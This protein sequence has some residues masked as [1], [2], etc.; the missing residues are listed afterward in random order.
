MEIKKLY[1]QDQEELDTGEDSLQGSSSI[2]AI[3]LQNSKPV[4]P[5]YFNQVSTINPWRLIESWETSREFKN[6]VKQNPGYRYKTVADVLFSVKE[7]LLVNYPEMNK[8]RSDLIHITHTMSKNFT[9]TVESYL[10]QDLNLSESQ[11]KALRSFIKLDR[12]YKKVKIKEVNFLGSITHEQ[13]ERCA[14]SFQEIGTLI[15]DKYKKNIPAITL[16]IQEENDQEAAFVKDDKENPM[17]VVHMRENRPLMMSEILHEYG[18]LIENYNPRVMSMTNDFLRERILSEDKCTIEEFSL[19]YN[20]VFAEW[21]KNEIIY[22]NDLMDPYMGKTYG[23]LMKSNCSS[24]LL[25]TG[26]QALYLDP[27]KL[28]L[29][30]P[31]C[32]KIVS[33]L[34]HGAI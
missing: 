7:N 11:V 2:S 16:V 14:K 15:P 27:I 22:P 24:E 9:S 21:N 26:L 3:L 19:Q 31:G 25:S 13:A 29:R 23:D 33:S 30:D 8:M 32:F 6:F 12:S 10:K 34:L 20:R 5:E 1:L 18:H 28:F 17:V 4:A